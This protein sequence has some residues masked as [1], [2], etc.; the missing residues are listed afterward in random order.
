[1]PRLEL[2]CSA[3]EKAAW[4][5]KAA[6]AGM[7]LSELV[8]HSLDK[9]RLPDKQRQKDLAALVREVAK[10]GNNLNQIARFANTYKS[11]ADTAQIV[12]HLAAIER[13]LEDVYQGLSPR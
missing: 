10:I 2:R 5:A 6:S 3:D 1:M 7:S 11:T 9:S 8:R 4:Q 13:I 12:A